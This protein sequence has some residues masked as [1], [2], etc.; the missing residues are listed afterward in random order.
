VRE[1]GM[2]RVDH[3]ERKFEL[4]ARKTPGIE[5]LRPECFTGDRGM[6]VDELAPFG[7]VAAVTPRT[8]PAP[9]LVNNAISLLAAGNSAVFNAHP[10]SKGV[11]AYAVEGLNEAIRAA[12][13]PANLISCIGSPTIETGQ[14]L[15]AQRGVALILVTGGPGVVREALRAPKRAICAGP[16]NPPVVVDETADLGKAAASIVD[17]GAFDNNVLCIGEKQ[18]LAVDAI[19]DRLIDELV[20]RGCR[21][22]GAREIERLTQ[23]VFARDERGRPTPRPEWMGRDAAVMARAI[24]VE[25]RGDPPLLVGETPFDHPFVQREQMMPFMP[26]VRCRNAEE[27]I[28]RAIESEH[29]YRHTAVIHSLDIRRLH[30]FARRARTTILV[31]NGSSAAG[32]ASGGEG[33]TSFSIAGTTGEG[34]T[35]ARTFTRPRRCTLVDYFRIV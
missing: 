29:G 8:H 14:A 27:A 2:G 17:G 13:G 34:L 19:V 26:I 22:I 31:K 4:V 9:T 16:G 28:D 11:F 30:D 7:V 18:V 3:K 5:I 10:A 35:T 32:L 6:T 20:D 25:A 24:G 15:F 33:T 23:T 1:T 12:G 21:A